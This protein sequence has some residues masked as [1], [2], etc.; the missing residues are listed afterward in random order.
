MTERERLQALVRRI[1]P[2][3]ALERSWPLAGGV[4]ADVTALEVE[5]PDGQT[6]KLI[7]RLHGEIDRAQNP[8][9]ARDEFNLLRIAQAHG[10]AVPAP[11]YV[12]DSCDLFPVPLIIIEFVDGVTEIGEANLS[13]Y[14]PQMAA[15]LAKIHAIAGSPD[16]A[17]L[18]RQDRGYGDRPAVLDASLGEERIRTAL[19]AAWPLT[20]VN[21]STLLH[22]DYWPGNIVW[23][24]GKLAAVIDWED[25]YVGDPLADVANCR[26]E[27]LW[28]FGNDAMD[29]FTD[30]YRSLTSVDFT[31]LSYW[32]LCAALRPCGKLSTWGLAARVEQRMQERHGSFVDQAIA[33]LSS[34]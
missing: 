13:A 11:Y 20:H 9:I 1:D 33:A 14:L 32:D 4:S 25:A 24:D 29:R 15:Q 31:N 2:G 5:L 6:K 12:D 23:S 18:P 7:V 26:L 19:E 30:H 16:L 21:E 17:F 28:G 8:T 10:L 34:Q 3:Y 22:G 27:L